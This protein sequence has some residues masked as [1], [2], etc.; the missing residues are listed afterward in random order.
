VQAG[1]YCKAAED[2][3]QLTK[4]HLSAQL[5]EFFNFVFCLSFHAKSLRAHHLLRFL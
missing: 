5:Y 2:N 4:I 1:R 3:I